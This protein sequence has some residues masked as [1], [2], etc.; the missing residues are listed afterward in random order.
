MG[1]LD[2]RVAIVTG[3]GGGIGREHAL[4]LGREGAA[5]VVDDIGS[6]TGSDAAAVADEIRAHGGTATSTTASAT[7]GG[8]AEI[9]A[10]AID[11]YGRSRHPGQQRHRGTQRRPVA[12]LRSRSGTSPWT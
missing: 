12:L 1:R 5:V 3:A 10:T 8:A 2:G 11:T 4:L 6:R 9:V 7:W